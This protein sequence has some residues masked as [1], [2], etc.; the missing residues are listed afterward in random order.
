MQSFNLS[1]VI[2]TY[3][4]YEY[5]FRFLTYLNDAGLK[6][7][8][9]FVM[10]DKIDA[11][12]DAKYVIN[13]YHYKKKVKAMENVTQIDRTVHGGVI[14]C[15]DYINDIKLNDNDNVVVLEDDLY[16][17]VEF[18]EQCQKFFSTIYSPTSPIFVGYSRP[19]VAEDKFFQTYS[20]LYMWGFAMKFGDLRKVINYHNLVRT[21]NF[22]QKKAI[23]YDV[24]DYKYPCPVFEKYKIHLMDRVKENFMTKEKESVDLYFMFYFLQNRM[25]ITKNEKSYVLSFKACPYD[26]ILPDPIEMDIKN[27]LYSFQP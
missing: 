7:K 18:F 13:A 5:V 23:I 6:F 16:A 12:K 1:I 14:G 27:M 21:Y 2:P 25:K 17:T 26:E 20:L 19:R 24:L 3:T 11:I 4:K 22:E 9:I 8:N 10:S 15:V